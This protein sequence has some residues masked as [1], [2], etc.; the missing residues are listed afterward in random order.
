MIGIFEA[1]RQRGSEIGTVLI[2]EPEMYLHPQAQR[3]FFGLL[4]KGL[5]GL[6]WCLVSPWGRLAA[7]GVGWP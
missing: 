1:F 7:R 6:E 5:E 3:Y 2:E 4:T